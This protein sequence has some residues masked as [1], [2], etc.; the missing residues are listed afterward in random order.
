MSLCLV[1]FEMT[2]CMREMSGGGGS[3][4]QDSGEML[5]PWQD[6]LKRRQPA[7]TRHLIKNESWGSEGDQI[8]P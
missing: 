5:G 7:K 8:P 6:E 4:C 3:D 1:V 2:N